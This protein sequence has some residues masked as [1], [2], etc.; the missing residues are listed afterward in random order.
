MKT[1]AT[2]ATALLLLG[3]SAALAQNYGNLDAAQQDRTYN[4]NRDQ[5]PS[6]NNQ[7][8]SQDSGQ[9]QEQGK[10]PSRQFQNGGRND[11]QLGA[12]G[13]NENPV[14]GANRYQKQSDTH[15]QARNQTVAK[16]ESAVSQTRHRIYWHDKQGRSHWRW[17][18]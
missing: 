2:V 10:D 5:N 12:Q 13:R 4:Q 9:S 14:Q 15:T 18:A 8:R 7:N 11:N 3:S 1:L 6:G 17:S 16:N